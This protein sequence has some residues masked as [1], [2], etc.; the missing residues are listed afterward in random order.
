MPGE[1]PISVRCPIPRVTLVKEKDNIL[2]YVHTQEMN[3]RHGAILHPRGE[4][5]VL[6]LPC[7]PSPTTKKIPTAHNMRSLEDVIVLI[8]LDPSEA[9]M[10]Q[11]TAHGE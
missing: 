10:N 8:V 3:V 11:L 7:D 4:V 5:N 2:L 6:V 1:N 9:D